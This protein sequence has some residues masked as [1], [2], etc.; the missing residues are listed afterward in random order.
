MALLKESPHGLTFTQVA[1]AINDAGDIQV[2]P[3]EVNAWFTK[4]KGRGIVVAL[5]KGGR[6]DPLRLILPDF[7]EAAEAPISVQSAEIREGLKRLGIRTPHVRWTSEELKD[8]ATALLEE[9][10]FYPF[11]RDLEYLVSAI[12]KVQE[13][14]EVKARVRH[15]RIIS[16]QA[17]RASGLLPVLDQL[18]LEIQDKITKEPEV[19]ERL[20]EVETVTETPYLEVLAKVPLA[21]RVQLLLDSIVGTV[22]PVMDLLSAVG[23]L[24]AK[25]TP[26]NPAATTIQIVTPPQSPTRPLRIGVVLALHKHRHSLDA[27]A[28]R[29]ADVLTLEKLGGED[30]RRAEVSAGLSAVVADYT[31]SGLSLLRK[32][33]KEAA[34][35]AGVDYYPEESW[36]NLENRILD[37]A[38]LRR[39]ELGVR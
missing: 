14:P 1:K 15:R 7:V 36:T 33:V 24:S 25:P 10:Y 21:E 9:I 20:V 28:R 30:D 11:G 38:M 26:H 35:K 31:E 22:R 12:N 32:G 19:V 39:K 18:L 34:K 5:G 3:I 27:L 23:S 13:K 2:K 37:L 29:V 6:G 17:I 16:L 8:L 4:N